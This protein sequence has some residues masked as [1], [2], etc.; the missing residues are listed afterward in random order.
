MAV[1]IW[2]YLVVDRIH[3]SVNVSSYQ[4]GIVVTQLKGMKDIQA[5]L[6][7][8]GKITMTPKKYCTRLD[9]Y[10]T[11]KGKIAEIEIG[12]NKSGHG[13]FKLV[14]YPS[15][16]GPGEFEH[17]REV[18]DLLLPA[19]SYE[20]L[21][22]TGRVSYIELAADSLTHTTH[23]FI[24]F[25]SRCNHSL[26][27]TE[28][29]EAKGSTYV[30]SKLSPLRHCIYDKRKQQLKKNLPALYKTHTR[31][32]SRSRHIGLSPCDLQAKMNNPFQRL[33]IADLQAARD[34][35]KDQT[36]HEFLD[37]CLEVGSAQA[38]VQHPK[39]RT[40]FMK[41]FRTAIA[42][43]WKPHDVWLG[44]PRALKVIAP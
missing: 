31:I 38:L 27:F 12:A 37:Q 11:K 29:D 13:Y 32:E 26:I 20:K 36:W 19:F 1:N 24:P 3:I 2:I 25:R 7:P 30:G 18:L 44:L 17:F 28:S 34:T 10:P 42:S 41:M 21:Y 8:D 40:Q 4:H 15:K 39:R 14:L 23:S 5:D 43:W 6:V 35:S 16:F 22:Q 33:E 9:Y